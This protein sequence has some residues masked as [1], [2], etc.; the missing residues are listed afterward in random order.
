MCNGD[1]VEDQVIVSTTNKLSDTTDTNPY[2]DS[3]AHRGAIVGD[4]FYIGYSYAKD[5]ALA[6]YT[7]LDNYNFWIRHYNVASNTWTDAQNISKIAAIDK[8]HVK[9]PRLVKTP[10]TGMGTTTYPENLQDKNTFIVA[11]GTETNVYSHVQSSVEGD[12]NY[13]RTRDQ[14]VTYEDPL[15]V[16]DL[17][18][19]NRFE[20]QLRPSPAGNIPWPVWNEAENAEDS[21]GDVVNIGTN[22]MLSVSDESVGTAPTPPARAE[23]PGLPGDEPP[24]LT[25]DDYNVAL[26]EFEVPGNAKFG[27]TKNLTS[28]I[29]NYGPDMLNGGTLTIE[30]KGYNEESEFI[31]LTTIVEPF[32]PIAFPDHKTVVLEWTAPEEAMLIDWVATIV[33][34]DDNTDD[35]NTQ[36]GTTKVKE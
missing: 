25:G 32:G 26:I 28:I 33:S 3:R 13:S 11:W 22:A 21:L 20:S 9:E 8:T 34:V 17:G 29:V 36:Y 23:T 2:E 1:T 18:I 6:T 19:N 31:Y 4:D 24:P 35:N 7:D 27:T 16:E 5:W 15:V 12:I 10:G 30:G 14:G